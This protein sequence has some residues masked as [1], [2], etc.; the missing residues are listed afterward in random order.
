MFSLS[1]YSTYSVGLGRFYYEKYFQFTHRKVVAAEFCTLV[2]LWFVLISAKDLDGGEPSDTILATQWLVLVS[3]HNTNFDNT[4]R[5]SHN[6][7]FGLC[8]FWVYIQVN[9]FLFGLKQ[10]FS[11][12]ANEQLP[13]NWDFITGVAHINNTVWKKEKTFHEINKSFLIWILSSQVG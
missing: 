1:V 13:L 8:S 11:L 9:L 10:N 3:I 5:K 6:T 7:Q 12:H 4:L 2:L